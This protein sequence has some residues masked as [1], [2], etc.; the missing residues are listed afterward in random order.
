MEDHRSLDERSAQRMTSGPLV[1]ATATFALA[2]L[3]AGCGS[4]GSPSASTTNGTPA[5][6]TATTSLPRPAAPQKE[7]ARRGP[8]GSTSTAGKLNYKPD[9]SLQTFGSEAKGEQKVEV[10]RDLLTFFRA[11]ARHDYARVCSGITAKNRRALQ[12]Y[13]QA[14]HEPPK[15]CARIL[16]TI[17]QPSDP[18]ISRAGR[19]KI[20]HV[21]IK[22]KDAVVFFRPP[23]E[24]V[25]YITMVREGA[26]WKSLSLV[27]GIPLSAVS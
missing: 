11:L 7:A 9:R 12:A 21:R 25:R 19:S 5:P 14:M 26:K 27:P 23:G 10:A 22:G 4:S 17:L 24:S 8:N 13:L 1:T 15:S 16:P 6:T 20:T 3:M 18:A 2:I